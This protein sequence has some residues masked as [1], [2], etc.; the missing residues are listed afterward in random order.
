[1]NVTR[2]LWLVAAP[3]LAVSAAS[4]QDVF[5]HERLTRT[6]ETQPGLRTPESVLYDPSAKVLYVANVN[7][8]PWEKDG[9]GFISKLALDG[10]FL[11][12]EWVKGL[13]APK[14]M[15]LANG[16][17]Y[18]TDIDELVEIDPTR[19]VVVKRYGHPAA[20]NLNDVATS[21]DGTVFVSDSAG[22]AIYRLAGGKLEVLLDSDEIAKT[23]GLF[24]LGG[25][26]L[27]GLHTKLVSLDLAT[28]VVE[29]FVENTGGIDGIAAVGD[30]T[31]LIS[32]WSGHVFLVA[33]GQPTV[34]LLDTTPK[35]INAA[36]IAFIPAD[37]TLL[38][39]TFFDDHVVA[40]RLK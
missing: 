36:D 15:G 29:P 39:P 16:H 4:A 32:D 11:A 40:Y 20:K 2:T 35:K 1:M 28:K 33:P 27:C 6:W 10:G 13:S 17:L 3:L 34:K 30:G 24:V 31:F 8:N 5:V 21:P 37:R 7:Q 9:N 26:L 22:H 23:N 18:V 25:D 14:G 38:V 19:A 12:L